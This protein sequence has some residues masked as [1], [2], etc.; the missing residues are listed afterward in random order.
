MYYDYISVE[1]KK[2]LALNAI[3]KLSKKNNIE[4]LEYIDPK[5]SKAWWALRWEENFKKNA[6]FSNRIGRGRTYVKNGFVIDFKLS[7]GLVTGLVMGSRKKPYEV[8]VYI[9]TLSE[10]EK[11][12]L[13]SM[14][15]NQVSS[16]D[17]LLKGEFSK[18]LQLELANNDLNL[19][20]SPNQIYHNCS[21]PDYAHTCKHVAAVLYGISS[22]IAANPLLFFTLRGIDTDSLIR[23]STDS[24]LNNMLLNSTVKS[25]RAINPKDITKLFQI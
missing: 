10:D 7:E 4:P 22:K 18:S 19:F 8:E 20:P 12:R 16:L 6:D 13:I 11:T 9:D 25:K 5:K 24:I 21:C 2:L 1:E 17:S 14:F 15:N 23:E 3:K